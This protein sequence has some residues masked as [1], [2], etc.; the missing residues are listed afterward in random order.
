MPKKKRGSLTGGRAA[1]KKGRKGPATTY[2][3]AQSSTTEDAGHR[4][5]SFEAAKQLITKQL[6]QVAL[7]QDEIERQEY[8]AAK[9]AIEATGVLAE[10]SAHVAWAYYYAKVLR[11]PGPKD[12]AAGITKCMHHTH[13]HHYLITNL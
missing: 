7:E 10:E 11:A 9:A 12:W 3:G 6:V 5:A 2:C 8:E 13:H 4:R 1:R